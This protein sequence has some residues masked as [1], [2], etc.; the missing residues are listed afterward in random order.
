MCVI[1]I[2]HTYINEYMHTCMCAGAH[3]QNMC[4]CVCMCVYIYIYIYSMCVC[5]IYIHTYTYEY[6]HTCMC[7][8][9]HLQNDYVCV[10]VCVCV[11]V[12]SSG[13]EC[14]YVVHIN[15]YMHACIVQ[16]PISKTTVLNK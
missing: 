4:M 12:H 9:A 1:P 16:V 10:C 5:G 6:M 14:S 13:H 15:E 7:A 2:I 11:C 8:G 3:L